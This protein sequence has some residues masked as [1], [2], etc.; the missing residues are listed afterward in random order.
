ML[1]DQVDVI[2]VPAS[3]SLNLSKGTL[4][5]AILKA[6]G[7]KIQEECFKNSRQS[8]VQ[9]GDIVITSGGRLQCQKMFHVVC[10][11]YKGDVSVS[12]SFILCIIL[13]V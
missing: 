9:N 12:A 11:H 3:K 8:S 5:K 4:S 6:A 13:Q 7:Q 10:P 1:T 2:V